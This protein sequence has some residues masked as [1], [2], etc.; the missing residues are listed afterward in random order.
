[1]KRGNL[2]RNKLGLKRRRYAW[3]IYECLRLNGKS[4]VKVAEALG[5]TPQNVTK[6][7]R[8]ESHSENVLNAL[9][10]AGVPERY[11]CDPHRVDMN[12]A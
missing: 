12:V 11:L 5:M 1:M 2:E 3:R 9:R 6:T 8:G 4:S 7:I 10:E